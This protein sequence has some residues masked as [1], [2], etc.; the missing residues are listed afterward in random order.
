MI[1]E[2]LFQQRDNNFEWDGKDA[3]DDGAQWWKSQWAIDDKIASSERKLWRAA[4]DKQEVEWMELHKQKFAT[5][6]REAKLYEGY[7]EAQRKKAKEALCA[8]AEKTDAE[9]KVE[10]LEAASQARFSDFS[11]SAFEEEIESGTSQSV[12]DRVQDVQRA[13]LENQRNQEKPECSLVSDYER[14]QCQE[15]AAHE[16]QSVDP[17]TAKRLL[18]EK[19][20]KV[21]AAHRK[22]KEHFAAFKALMKERNPLLTTMREPGQEAPPRSRMY[23]SRST[24]HNV[25]LLAARLSESEPGFDSVLDPATLVAPTPLNRLWNGSSE[26][27]SERQDFYA[28]ASQTPAKSSKR[29]PRVRER[30]VPM[31]EIWN[32]VNRGKLEGE[33]QKEAS[34]S[35]TEQA[36]ARQSPTQQASA[37]HSPEQYSPGSEGREVKRGG[38]WTRKLRLNQ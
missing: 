26:T 33:E 1:A 17:E 22:Q 2:C 36:S 27:L 20:K 34:Q 4:R 7:L 3:E 21:E 25:N 18:E 8:A 38:W 23:C 35:P 16:K 30:P 28:G 31:S 5:N 9:T 15:E 19:L 24:F 29:K 14:V 11:F 37:Q 32:V 10:L 12:L 6:P 13:L